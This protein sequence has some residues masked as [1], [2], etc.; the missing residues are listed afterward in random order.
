MAQA[1]IE[2]RTGEGQSEKKQADAKKAVKSAQ[3]LHLNQLGR[4][5]RVFLFSSWGAP[6]NRVAHSKIGNRKNDRRNNRGNSRLGS[7]YCGS[8][9]VIGE[10]GEQRRTCRDC[11]GGEEVTKDEWVKIAEKSAGLAE[12]I[13]K[14]I[15]E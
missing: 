4:M 11:K 7:R 14:A 15:R 6:P 5:G 8:G 10:K 1:L 12:A 13:L 2:I 3:V 9:K